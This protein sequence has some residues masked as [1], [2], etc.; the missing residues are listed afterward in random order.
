VKKKKT[1]LPTN[2]RGKHTPN[3]EKNPKKKNPPQNKPET[4]APKKKSKRTRTKT[5]KNSM[6]NNAKEEKKKEDESFPRL[7]EGNSCRRSSCGGLMTKQPSGRVK[8]LSSV[9]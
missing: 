2:V 3:P 5:Q 8:P 9:R 6:S 4:V 1:P 7:S